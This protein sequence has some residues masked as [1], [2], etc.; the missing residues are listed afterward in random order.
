L[1]FIAITISDSE[2][3]IIDMNNRSIETFKRSGGEALIGQNLMECH[4]KRAQEIIKSLSENKQT[5]AYT[6]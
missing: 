5:N 1:P 2:G 4:S 3:K 6:I